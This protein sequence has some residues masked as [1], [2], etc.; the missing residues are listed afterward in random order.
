MAWQ[1]SCLEIVS[2]P[3][4]ARYCH[5]FLRLDKTSPNGER[6]SVLIQ[7][8]SMLHLLLLCCLAAFPHSGTLVHGSMSAMASLM[9][10]MKGQY[11]S[12]EMMMAKMAY[13]NATAMPCSAEGKTTKDCC[14]MCD[15]CDKCE[16][17]KVCDT[18]C[19]DICKYCPQ[20]PTDCVKSG[21]CGLQCNVAGL[22][23]ERPCLG[24]GC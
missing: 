6:V 17:C 1:I 23:D 9:S 19:T 22:P 20:C 5:L 12:S 10:M 8:A 24:C 2:P 13:L 21:Y 18:M 7:R 4:L 11:S 14:S 3:V 16:A 15:Y